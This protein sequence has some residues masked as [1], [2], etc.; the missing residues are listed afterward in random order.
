MT[1]LLHYAF[2]I[3]KGALTCI[4]AQFWKYQEFLGTFKWHWWYFVKNDSP[5]NLV[6]TIKQI[7]LPRS[8]SLP[9]VNYYI[10][11]EYIVEKLVSCCTKRSSSRIVELDTVV[12][13]ESIWLLVRSWIS[14]WVQPS[15]MEVKL[16]NISRG[17]PLIVVRTFLALILAKSLYYGHLDGV[18]RIQSRSV[19]SASH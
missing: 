19:D 8:R 9:C 1:A 16:W 11:E 5:T 3:M 18:R 13:V 10:V 14:W 7:E 12:L 2:P 6:A 17:S 15:K 4:L